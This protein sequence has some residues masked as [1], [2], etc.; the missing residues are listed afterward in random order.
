MP[1]AL[2]CGTAW[3]FAT[4]NSQ[5]ASF[6]DPGALRSAPEITETGRQPEAFAA[7]DPGRRLVR[8]PDKAAWTGRAAIIRHISIDRE[9]FV[10]EF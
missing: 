9:T 3:P 4:R 1:E 7:R 2:R 10:R 8:E 6:F 5:G